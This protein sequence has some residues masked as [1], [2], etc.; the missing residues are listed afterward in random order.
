[1]HACPGA[2]MGHARSPVRGRCGEPGKRMFKRRHTTYPA[3]AESTSR[4]AT[5][6]MRS[7]VR[8]MAPWMAGG[9]QEQAYVG[10]RLSRGTALGAGEPG[11]VP[12]GRS[13]QVEDGNAEGHPDRLEMISALRTGAHLADRPF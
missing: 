9:T 3:W 13:T 8:A 12:G 4:A 5:S 6:P 7:R 10:G 1:M 11:G 2:P